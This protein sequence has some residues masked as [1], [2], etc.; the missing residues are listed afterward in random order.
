MNRKSKGQAVECAAIIP[1]FFLFVLL[2]LLDLACI[3]L[4]S[5][6]LEGAARDAV[7][8][9]AKAKSFTSAAAASEQTARQF[10]SSF[11]GARISSIQTSIVVAAK[12]GSGV[13]RFTGKLPDSVLPDT[14]KSVFQ[15]E[16]DVV[17]EV[18]PLIT[19]TDV[20]GKIPGLSVPIPFHTAA[21]EVFESPALLS[22]S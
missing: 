15:I 1:V 18:S 6:A 2:P 13:Q 3:T 20:L 4:R 21:R 10:A 5:F 16:V 12:D 17:G 7:H 14:D 11:D 9:A 19:F 22:R 8:H